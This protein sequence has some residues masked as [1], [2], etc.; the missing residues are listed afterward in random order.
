MIVEP[1]VGSLAQPIVLQVVHHPFCIGKCIRLRYISAVNDMFDRLIFIDD[2][3][4]ELCA[5]K[6]GKEVLRTR[7]ENSV[8]QVAVHTVPIDERA[9]DPCNFHQ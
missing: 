6:F 1:Y 3:E 8:I 5:L 7:I 2:A 4:E 9:V